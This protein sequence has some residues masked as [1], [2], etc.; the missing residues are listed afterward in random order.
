MGHTD[1]LFEKIE[2]EAQFDSSKAASS[3]QGEDEGEGEGE[4]PH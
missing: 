2:E 4:S 1:L 3:E